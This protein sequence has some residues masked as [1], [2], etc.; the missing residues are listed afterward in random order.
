VNGIGTNRQNAKTPKRQNAKTPKEEEGLGS[1]SMRNRILNASL[2]DPNSNPAARLFN[3][4]NERP[5]PPQN[6]SLPL[7]AFWRFGGSK[8]GSR[9]TRR[10]DV[11]G[12]TRLNAQ[13]VSRF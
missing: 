3:D 7:L 10:V 8:S 1:L 11:T 2:L 5:E 4:V 12:V 6:L 13:R 9:S